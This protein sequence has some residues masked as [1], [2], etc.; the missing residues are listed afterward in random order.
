MRTDRLCP[1]LRSGRVSGVHETLPDGAA[2]PLSTA[3][4][5]PESDMDMI[6]ILQCSGPQVAVLSF[7]SEP[8]ALIQM[9]SILDEDAHEKHEA[10]GV[11]LSGNE[12]V[13]S[14]WPLATTSV[15]G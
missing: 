9:Q 2:R 14:T 1:S 10:A 5:E 15:I 4:G 11:P 3:V 13:G 8:S 6:G 7:G 12:R